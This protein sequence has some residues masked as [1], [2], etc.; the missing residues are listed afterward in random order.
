MNWKRTDGWWC[1]SFKL[2]MC[3]KWLTQICVGRWASDLF[4]RLEKLI[5]A[6]SEYEDYSFPSTVLPLCRCWVY[7][8]C[9]LEKC[10]DFFQ[11]L[12]TRTASMSCFRFKWE[13]GSNMTCSSLSIVH[14]TH[15]AIVTGSGITEIS[16]KRWNM[17]GVHFCLPI[18][19][20]RTK[21]GQIQFNQCVAWHMHYTPL[22]IGRVFAL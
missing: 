17:V 15:C 1:F 18:L 12:C 8:T 7:C 14:I 9:I 4:A 2:S 19:M 6:F 10:F 13:R 3:Y 5:L 11:G 22:R 20:Q 16:H 21:K